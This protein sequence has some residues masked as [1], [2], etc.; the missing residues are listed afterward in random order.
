[1]RES[2]LS[3]YDKHIG[4]HKMWILT[5]DKLKNHHEKRIEILEKRKTDLAYY[6]T[7]NMGFKK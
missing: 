7:T 2:N 5:Y 3:T 1:M 4:I 6:R